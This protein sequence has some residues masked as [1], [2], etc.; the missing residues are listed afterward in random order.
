MGVPWNDRLLI[1]SRAPLDLTTRVVLM[2]IADRTEMNDSVA[3]SEGDHTVLTHE[4]NCVLIMLKGNGVDDSRINMARVRRVAQI[5][6]E[7]EKSNDN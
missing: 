6:I 3:M 2:L 4:V 5:L 1:A 7:L